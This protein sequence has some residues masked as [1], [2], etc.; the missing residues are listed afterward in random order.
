[1][2]T[3]ERLLGHEIPI[4]PEPFLQESEL[5]PLTEADYQR[6]FEEFWAAPISDVGRDFGIPR[7]HLY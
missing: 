7:G 2:E 4:L 3:I 5:R 1:M 6:L